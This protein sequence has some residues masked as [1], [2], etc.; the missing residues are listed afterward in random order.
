VVVDE[1]H[2]THLQALTIG[3]DYGTSLEVLQGLNANDWIVLNPADSLDDGMQ[4]NVKEVPQSAPPAEQS[5]RGNAAP[6]PN[7]GPT[8]S[9]ATTP[10]GG[11]Q[12]STD[13]RGAA[14]ERK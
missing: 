14:G 9:G 3:R 10:S 5:P 4:V 13:G 11:V 2:K 7:G 12:P 6:S 1:N 8:K